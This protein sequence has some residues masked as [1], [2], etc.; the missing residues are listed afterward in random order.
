[1]AFPPELPFAVAR[2]IVCDRVSE[3]KSHSS[4]TPFVRRL[5]FKLKKPPPSINSDPSADRQMAP[6]YG[7]VVVS[8][9]SRV[10]LDTPQSS[11][12]PFPFPPPSARVVP[13]FEKATAPTPSFDAV[14]RVTFSFPLATFQSSSTPEDGPAE[15]FKLSPPSASI[16]PS[17]EKATELITVFAE[18]LRENV[19]VLVPAFHNSMTPVELLA[20]PIQS[21]DPLGEKAIELTLEVAP[22]FRDCCWTL[23]ETVHSSSTPVVTPFAGSIV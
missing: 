20:P 5:A 8:L 12:T 6:T 19:S 3:A 16:V 2:L 21:I 13:S 1:M 22:V 4:K 15:V 11:R 7:L 9:V 10:P 18:V 23:V 17:E 14:G